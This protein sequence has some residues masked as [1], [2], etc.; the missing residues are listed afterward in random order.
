MK[1]TVQFE[2]FEPNQ[3][4]YFDILRLAEL[5]KRLDM[6]I[7]DVIRKGDAGINFCLAGLQVGLKHHYYKATPDDYAEK[8]E[9]YLEGG[10]TIDEIATLIIKAIMFSGIFGKDIVAKLEGKLAE[11]EGTEEKNA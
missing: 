7:A 3:T 5:E 10:G 2:L 4:I 9:K 6:P 11:I 8:I 1:K